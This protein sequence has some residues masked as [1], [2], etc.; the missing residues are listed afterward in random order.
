MGGNGFS[1]G[2]RFSELGGRIRCGV[3]RWAGRS[4]KG[5]RDALAPGGVDLDTTS[6][7]RRRLFDQD[8]P[9]TSLREGARSVLAGRCRA[10]DRKGSTKQS[11]RFARASS[12][13]SVVRPNHTLRYDSSMA[14]R[15][16]DY[17]HVVHASLYQSAEG[18][19]ASRRSVRL[20]RTAHRKGQDRDDPRGDGL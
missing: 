2:K 19:R 4:G 12:W 14:P 18:S 7:R 13:N 17:R 9:R 20:G 3:V 8:Q 10:R 16:V 15:G 1:R 5:Q 6:G 11:Q